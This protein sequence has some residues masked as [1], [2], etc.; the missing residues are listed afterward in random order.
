MHNMHTAAAFS[1]D[2]AIMRF[3]SENICCEVLQ[4]RIKFRI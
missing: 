4:N 3:K 2:V 1:T